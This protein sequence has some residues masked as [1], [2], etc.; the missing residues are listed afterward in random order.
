MRKQQHTISVVWCASS[1]YS[2]LESVWRKKIPNYGNIYTHRRKYE[3][4]VLSLIEVMIWE[5]EFAVRKDLISM[6]ALIYSQIFKR[7]PIFDFHSVRLAHST[8]VKHMSILLREIYWVQLN[9]YC[10]FPLLAKIIAWLQSSILDIEFDS[11]Q[12]TVRIDYR[13]LQCIIS[14]ISLDANIQCL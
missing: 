8:H 3:Y 14:T 12:I 11:F 5:C 4:Y 9:C 7:F 10:C 2:L 6:L 1:W 13:A